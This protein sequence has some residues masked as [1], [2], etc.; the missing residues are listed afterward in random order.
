MTHID[1]LAGLPPTRRLLVN[2]LR[3]CLTRVLRKDAGREALPAGAP[4]V[5]FRLREEIRQ[6]LLYFLARQWPS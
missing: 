3:T 2:S 5:L 4:P 1:P 6:Q